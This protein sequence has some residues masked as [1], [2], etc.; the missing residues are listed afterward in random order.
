MVESLPIK[1]LEMARAVVE[2]KTQMNIASSKTLHQTIRSHGRGK[3]GNHG[4]V[5][6]TAQPVRTNSLSMPQAQRDKD[7]SHRGRNIRVTAAY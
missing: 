7:P 1:L 6:G 3:E 5:N 4:S 2:T